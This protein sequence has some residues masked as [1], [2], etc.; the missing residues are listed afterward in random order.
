MTEGAVPTAHSQPARRRHALACLWFWLWAIVGVSGALG[1]LGLGPI[2]LG[3]AMIASVAMSTSRTARRSAPGLL[4]GPGLVSLLVAYGQRQGP[5]TTCWH[6][7]TA[8]AC[9]QHLNPVP[10]LMI[11]LL[12]LTGAI[13]LQ[14]RQ[15]S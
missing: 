12:L 15:G 8:S 6:T 1:L 4:A 11:G 5:G 3:P 10:W 13:L 2:A 9:D 14:K 7:A